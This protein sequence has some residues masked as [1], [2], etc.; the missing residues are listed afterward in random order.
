MA[1]RFLDEFE[2]TFMRLKTKA[3]RTRGILKN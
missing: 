1:V 2:D 3:R